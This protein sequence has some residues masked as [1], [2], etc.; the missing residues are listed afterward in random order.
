LPPDEIDQI[1]RF[2]PLTKEK[3]LL[4]LSAKKESGKYTE[5][6]FLSPTIDALFRHVPPRLYLAIAATEQSEKSHRAS[7]MQKFNCSKMEAIEI[8]A[9]E[10][11]S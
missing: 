9:N 8:I 2:K 3:E 11:M 7:I 5:G 4:F 1:K 10:M 6:V